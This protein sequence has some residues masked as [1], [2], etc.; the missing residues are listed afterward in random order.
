[1]SHFSLT[2]IFGPDDCGLVRCEAT[3]T[4]HQ[5]EQ[6]FVY[7][8]WLETHRSS[9]DSIHSD[10]M[11][12]FATHLSKATDYFVS[13]P[14]AIAF[15][16]ERIH[17]YVND[18]GYA[19]D[20]INKALD[21]ARTIFEYTDRYWNRF[22]AD[23]RAEVQRWA[24]NDR[25]EAVSDTA[26]ASGNPIVLGAESVRAELAEA[27]DA[28]NLTKAQ[29]ERIAALP[30]AEIDAAI[31]DVV[32]DS[33][34]EVYDSMRHDAIT[35]LAFDPL[36][37]IVFIQ[38]QGYEDAVDAAND[39]GGSTEAVVEHLAQWD[40]GEENDSA[41]EVNG[42]TELTELERLPHQLHEVDHG[43]LHYWL[44][45]DHRLGFYGLYRRPLQ[46]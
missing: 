20:G 23:E 10:I 41:S 5:S 35:R 15:A 6:I 17:S 2:P 37:L 39:S 26:T 34:W 43:G 14:D 21:D 3:I 8:C 27:R 9:L 13:E 44:E 45:V 36:V 19:K 29:A 28:H 22:T 32:D 1:M 4:T 24:A 25:P 7:T 33:F 31:H 40:Y 46:S 18:E 38:G 11:S 42:R 12:H 30:D 16:A